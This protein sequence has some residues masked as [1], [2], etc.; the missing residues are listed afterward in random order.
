MIIQ[1]PCFLITEIDKVHR[2]KWVTNIRQL[3]QERT[4]VYMCICEDRLLLRCQ[5]TFRNKDKRAVTVIFSKD[6]ALYLKDLHWYIK[7]TNNLKKYADV[8]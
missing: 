8:Q 1:H 7:D 6:A 2:I 3:K 5:Y 4:L